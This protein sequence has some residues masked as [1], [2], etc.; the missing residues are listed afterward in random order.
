M[1]RLNVISS[2]GNIFYVLNIIPYLLAFKR[3]LNEA[4]DKVVTFMY[5]KKEKE[6]NIEILQSIQSFWINEKI[7]IYIYFFLQEV[8]L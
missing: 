5:L 2:C 7:L 8:P 4:L 1:D 6:K 3:K